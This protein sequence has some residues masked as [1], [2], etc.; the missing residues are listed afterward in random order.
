MDMELSSLMPVA[1]AQLQPRLRAHRTDYEKL[2]TDLKRLSTTAS[3]REALLSGASD[4]FSQE[5]AAMD[6][7]SRL[8][9]GTHKLNDASKRLADSHRIA[10]ETE[11]VGQQT[12][13]TL[14]TQREQI[15]HANDTL[16]QTNTYIDRN[17]RLLKGMARR[18]F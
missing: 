8:L 11:S 3:D 7:R 12:L 15:V 14:R 6:Q 5:A 17:V 18:W 4:G 1:K 13:E 10:L 16:D 2:R 9:H